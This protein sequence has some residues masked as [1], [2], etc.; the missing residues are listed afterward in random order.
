V[1]KKKI[2]EPIGPALEDLSSIGAIVVP[3]LR[4]DQSGY[5]LGQGGGYYD[6]ALPHLTAWK[7]GLVYAGEL[8]SETLPHEAHDIPLDAAASPSIVVRFNR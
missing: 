5:R 6:R 2:S 8:N 4:I 3:A 1:T 7:I